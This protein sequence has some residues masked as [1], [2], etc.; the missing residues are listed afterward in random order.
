MNIAIIT[1]CP[2]GVANSILAAGLLEQAAAKLNW[3]AKIECQSS[4]VEPTLL[5]EADVEQAEVIVIA[6]N[7]SVDTSRFVGKKVYQAEISEVAK[8]AT[9]FLQQAVE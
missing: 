1:A 2:S 8:D 9:A 5:T 7:T 3:N 6:A 4:V